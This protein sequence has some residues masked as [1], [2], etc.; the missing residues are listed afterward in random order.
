M[1]SPASIAERLLSHAAAGPSGSGECLGIAQ[2]SSG[3]VYKPCKPSR[4]APLHTC[5]SSALFP[6]PAE[7][8]GA[9]AGRTLHLT[10]RHLQRQPV[11]A[12]QQQVGFRQGF[13]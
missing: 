6:L 4:Q 13:C 5:V 12:P 7:A 11:A 1:A 2:T 3:S 9:L 8:R 10:S